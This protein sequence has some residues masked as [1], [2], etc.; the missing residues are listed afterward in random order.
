MS[1]VTTVQDVINEYMESRKF[2][3][4]RDSSQQQYI[5]AFTKIGK[6]MGDLIIADVK[7]RD[8]IRA[9]ETLRNTPAVA[10][11][12]SRIA[13]VLFNY[14]LDMD[15][16]A[17]NPAARLRMATTGSWSRWDIKDIAQVINMGH[18]IVSTAVAIAFFTG[19]RESDVL[20]M[21]WSDIENGVIRVTQQ[22]TGHVLEIKMAEPLRQFLDGLERNGE[23][24]VSGANR[25][26]GPAFRN[27]FKRVT[28]SI[29]LDV[30]FHGIR[31]TVGAHL[32]EQGHSTNEIAALLGHKTLTMAAHYTR[33]ASEKKMIASA[34]TGLA[35][36]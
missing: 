31:K 11:R 25:M 20:N 34:V 22:K 19:Q 16:I 26:S 23:Y 29:G 33:Q 6:I 21:R 28:R 12:F 18:R 17:A 14:A 27:M 7:R 35:F 36:D 2:S 5:F 1:K 15:Y 24:I 4:L 13:S 30:Q 32:A 10:N 8:V 9:I 3:E